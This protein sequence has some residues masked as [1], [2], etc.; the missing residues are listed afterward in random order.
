MSSGSSLTLSGA[1]AVPGLAIG[2]AVGGAKIAQWGV[3]KYKRNQRD[4]IDEGFKRSKIVK[5][6]EK[7]EGLTGELEGG[8]AL[9]EYIANRIPYYM[10]LVE[11]YGK[12][13]KKGRIEAPSKLWHPINYRKYKN[14]EK[15][16]HALQDRKKAAAM[17]EKDKKTYEKTKGKTTEDIHGKTAEDVIGMMEANPEDRKDIEKVLKLK[18]DWDKD[19][20]GNPL[21]MKKKKKAVMKKLDW[22]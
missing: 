6:S 9:D 15:Q 10:D 14:A 20:D 21:E 7:L 13:N 1:G 5:K 2:A 8:L 3:K 18:K 12:V 17:Y 16:L 22:F 4:A 11:K 19:D